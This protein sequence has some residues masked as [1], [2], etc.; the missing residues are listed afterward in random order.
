[1]F[2]ILRTALRLTWLGIASAAVGPCGLLAAEVSDFTRE[3]RPLLSDRCFECHGPDTNHRQADL[4]LD[5]QSEALADRG[6][7]AALVPG[8]LEESEIWRRISSEDEFERMP[9]PDAGDAL[10]DE[11]IDVLRRW[12]ES[13]A[14]WSDHWAYVPPVR[15]PIPAV[16]RTQWPL[17]W[18]DHFVLARTEHEQVEPSAE[19]DRA[20]LIR[21]IH[22]DLTGLPPSSSDVD[23]FLADSQPN[24]Y[25]RLVDRL[26]ASPA[27]GERLAVYWLDCV[28]F[29]DTVGYHGD[30]DHHISPYR[31]YVIDSLNLNVPFDRFTIEQ[32]AGDLLADAGPDQ[33]IAAAYNRMLQTSH[34]GGV[35]PKEYLSIYQADRVRNVSAVWLGATLGCAQ[36]H[37]HK[38]DPYTAQDFYAMAAFF[39]DVDEARHLTRGA[40]TSPTIRVPEEP[41]LTRIERLQLEQLQQQVAKFTRRLRA[42]D[43][44]PAEQDLLQQELNRLEGMHDAIRQRARKVMVTVSIAP[45][46]VRILPRGDWLDESGPVVEPSSPEFLPPMTPQGERATRLDLARW[47]VDANHGAGLLTARVMVNRLWYLMFGQGLARQL[48]D[49]GGQGTPPTHPA[50]LR[51]PGTRVCG[52]RMGYQACLATDCQ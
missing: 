37:D 29:A 32:L 49:F 45:R 36:C 1:V 30:Q 21:R 16:Q 8:R 48:D 18:I 40:D 3:I 38:Y 15:T 25:S 9:P 47:L 33:K 52:K 42:A 24:A 46:E 35:Q 51:S 5:V 7:Y 14:T 11:E 6:G 41:V 26:L 44:R 31:D 4:R 10:T 27:F 17:N 43:G 23:A 34:E 13:G 20:T 39:A 2:S 19:A 22:F 50:T 12:I 28:R